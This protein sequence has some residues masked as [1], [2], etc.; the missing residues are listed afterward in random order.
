MTKTA[1]LGAGSWGTALAKLVADRG[2]PV[3]LWSR[4][5][6]QVT[7]INGS[8]RNPTY[9]TDIELPATL[10]ATSDLEDALE[11]ASLVIVVV[12]TEAVRP[13]LQQALPHIPEDAA[14]LSATKGIEQGTLELVSEIFEDVFPKER[15]RMLTYLGGPSFAK[16]VA[17]GVPTAVCVA[18]HDEDTRTRVAEMLTTNRFRVYTT[19]DVVGIELGGAL[20]NVVAI[21]AGVAD[22]M[23]LGHNTRAALITRGLAELG[24]LAVKLGADPLTLA[25]LGGMGDLVLTCTGDL[26]RNRQ[27]GIGLGKGK[28]LPQILEELGMVAEG[29][30]TAK[31]AHELGEREGI[32]MPI[33]DQV[34]SI[35]YEDL[36]AQQALVT[37]M[38]RPMKDERG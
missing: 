37:L 2:E 9:L 8:R 4:R 1:V 21:A 28:K 14:I 20:K 30:R 12:P 10:R 33:T 5:E 19:D 32:E 23:N 26:S 6:E 36:P 17:I 31:S 7:A 34:Y 38:T 13:L 16:E 15:H 24:R 27:V 18:G 25:G 22:G 29:V 11:G 3:S 35:L